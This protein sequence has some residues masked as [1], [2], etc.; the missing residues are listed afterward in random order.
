MKVDQEVAPTT[1][2]R[3]IA[4][5]SDE[6]ERC[7][8]E[9]YLAWDTESGASEAMRAVFPKAE[10]HP[11]VSAYMTGISLCLVPGPGGA[12]EDIEGLYVPVG[13]PGRNA[14]ERAVRGLLRAMNRTRATQITH[15]CLHDWP[16]LALHARRGYRPP[17]GRRG[18]ARPHIDTQVVAWHQDENRVKGLKPLDELYLGGDAQEEADAIKAMREAPFARVTDARLAVLL[19]YPELGETHGKGKKLWPN[20]EAERLARQLTKARS[21]GQITAAEMAPYAAQ[22]ATSTAGLAEYLLQA[23]PTADVL[24]KGQRRE[25]EYQ[26]VLYRMTERGVSVNIDKLDAGAKDYLERAEILGDGLADEFTITLGGHEVPFENPT[27][28]PQCRQVLY[29]KLGLPVMGRSKKTGD[30]STDKNALEMLQGHPV[31]ARILEYRKWMHAAGMATTLGNHARYS[32][33]G[34]IHG[35]YSSTQTVTG[36]LSASGPNVM[37][38]PRDDSLPEIRR[39]FFDTPPGIRRYGFDINSAELWV[40]AS[41]TKDPLLCTT[42]LEGRNL[43]VETMLAVFGGEPD[44]TRREY[45][46]SKNVNF[47]IEYGAGID[48]ITIFAAK[49]G[50]SP[51]EARRVAKQMVQ[52][53]KDA[54]AVQHRMARFLSDYATKH[55]KIPL[56]GGN[57]RYRHFWSPGKRIHSY[58]ALNALVQGGVAEFVKDTM[59]AIDH[60]WARDFL[61]LQVHDELAFDAPDEPGMEAKLLRLLTKI[62]KDLSPFRY[63]LVWSAKQWKEAA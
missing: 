19:A 4:R 8:P 10:L 36:R 49:A 14:P 52:G 18:R 50:Y 35:H 21:W 9:G 31:A 2:P 3:E 59:I 44:K 6:I 54:Y 30:P 17:D 63:P 24:T 46:L 39:A 56:Y 26:G 7:G 61:V 40:T 1:D 12:P 43:H 13:H 51:R 33:D 27:S 23:H 22:D 53:H 20:E 11:Y 28:A 62:A 15:H 5:L 25:H 34:R 38:I 47:G 41:V 42:L 32:V 55:G 16:I 60:S 45:T 48:Q 58:T 29:G 37:N 57:D